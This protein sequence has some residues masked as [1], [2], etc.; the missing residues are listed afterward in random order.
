V[1][2]YHPCDIRPGTIGMIKAEIVRGLIAQNPELALPA[3]RTRVFAD[4]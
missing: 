2:G 4:G 1:T 3:N